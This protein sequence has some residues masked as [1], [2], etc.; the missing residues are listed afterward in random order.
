MTKDAASKERA[1]SLLLS[2]DQ[3]LVLIWF[4]AFSKSD[5]KTTK[6]AASIERVNSY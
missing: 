5:Q 3:M 6:V 2:S 4:Q 1:D